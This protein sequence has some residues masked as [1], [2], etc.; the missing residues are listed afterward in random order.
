MKTIDLSD[1]KIGDTAWSCEEGEVVIQ[2]SLEGLNPHY[3][4]TTESHSYTIE[5]KHYKGDLHPVLFRSKQEFL[6]YWG[7]EPK[8][9]S[10]QLTK[11][12]MFAMAAMQ[13]M[14]SNS[15]WHEY[16]EHELVK[17]AI[18]QADALIAKLNE[19]P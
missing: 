9:E 15:D 14:L 3:P 4:I 16:E 7:L 12:E 8:I 2:K 13:G 10:N 6:E 18:S 17:W 19:K 5:G 11:R 1:L